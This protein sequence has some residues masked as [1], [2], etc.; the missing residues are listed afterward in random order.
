MKEEIKPRD[1]VI[2]D[3]IID[4]T[5]NR[6]L[7][8]FGNGL[9]AHVSFADPFCNCLRDTLYKATKKVGCKTHFGGIYV[10]MEGPQFSTR[11]E[12]NLHRAWGASVIGMTAIPEAKLAREAEMCYA[13][14]ALATDYDCW[15]EEEEAVTSDAVMEIVKN[16]S[17]T[18]KKII[19][20]VLPMISDKRKCSCASALS[21]SL[22]TPKE[23]VPR[24]TFEKVKLLVGKYMK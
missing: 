13:S 22:V 8:F 4:K 7:S 6:P 20:A 19:K 18:A 16:N 17:D 14:I 2:P 12:S 1:I 5:K 11:A 10:C 24:E 21:V 23:L 15:H 9:V 3:Q